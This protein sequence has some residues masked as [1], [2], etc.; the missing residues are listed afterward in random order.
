MDPGSS[1]V[2]NIT[3]SSV[4][5]FDYLRECVSTL[6]EQLEEFC[7]EEIKNISDKGK[8]TNMLLFIYMQWI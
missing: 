8:V 3:G 7:Q 4:L 6:R 1:D 2:P 5:Y